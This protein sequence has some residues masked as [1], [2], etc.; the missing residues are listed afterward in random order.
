M[1]YIEV[2][3]AWKNFVR[4]CKKIIDFKKKK[5][6][7][8]TKEQ[9]DS[10]ENAKIYYICKEKLENKYVKDKIYC[11]VRDHCHYAREY[12]CNLKYSAPRKIS[13]AF[14]NGSDYD[15]HFIIKEQEKLKTL[16]SI[17]S[18]KKLKKHNVY[19]SNRNRS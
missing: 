7:L 18:G 9:Q 10:Y 17:C 1:T 13:T 6:K 15:Y 8:L 12:R 5:I 3:I 19:K 16:K 4:A 2:K 14:R 11:K